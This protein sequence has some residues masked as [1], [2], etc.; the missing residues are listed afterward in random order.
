MAPKDADAHGADDS[1]ITTAMATDACVVEGP[2]L[3]GS[4]SPFDKKSYRQILLPNGLRVVL[5]S[6]T[7]AMTQA[8]NLGGILDD[9]DDD[10]SEDDDEDDEDNENEN[11][12]DDMDVD[13]EGPED[14]DDDDEEEE[15]E[16]GGLR[17]A[18]AAMIVGVGSL[19]DPPECQGM[20]HFLEHL[21]F[22]GSEKYPEENSYD[23]YMSKH[24]GHDN[25][26][27]E[28]EHTV[29]HFEIPQEQLAGALDLFAQFFVAPLLKESSVD[30]EL[31][32]IESEFMLAKSSD[33][34]RTSQLMA[35]TN[36]RSFEEHPA[37]KFGWGNWHSL[38]TLPEKKGVE[39]LKMLRKFYDKV[40]MKVGRVFGTLSL[41]MSMCLHPQKKRFSC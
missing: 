34:S 40:C 32:A 38:K 31:K 41:K 23:A 3:N 33:C 28:N 11:D 27:T 17:N 35:Y 12:A 2:D 16:E 1:P 5:V 22:M 18:A 14:D 24:G 30:R 8:Y 37:S 9:E 20:A 10:F 26:Y 39:P 6:D 7:V 21:L 36:G 15:E 25:A 13:N 29:Y 4:R 19:Y